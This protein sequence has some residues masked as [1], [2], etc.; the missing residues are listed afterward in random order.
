MKILIDGQTLST[1]DIHRG[2]GVVFS[3]ILVNLL[4]LGPYHEFFLAVYDDYAKDQI[5]NIQDTIEILRLGKKLDASSDG[6]ISYADAI[7][8]IVSEK[9]IDCLWIPNPVMPNVNFIKKPLECKV[10]ITFYDL[11]PFIFEEYYLN[12]WPANLKE[13]YLGRLMSLNEIGDCILP[14]SNCTK[15]DLINLLNIDPSKIQTVYLGIERGNYSRENK[16][17]D[18][19]REKY[20]LYVGGFDPRK[21]MMNSILAF[22]R[23]TEKYPYP[24]LKYYIVCDCDQITRDNFSAYIKDQSLLEKVVLTGY[25]SDRELSMLYKN[26][27]LLFFPSLYEGF[28]LPIIEA[29]AAGTPVAASNR[30]SIPEL[31]GDAGLL[32]DPENIDDMALK[33]HQI[34]SD[35]E[36]RERLISNGLQISKKFSWEKTAKQYLDIIEGLPSAGIS[37]RSHKIATVKESKLKIAYFSPIHPQISGISQYSKE[38]LLE[39]KKYADIDLFLDKNVIPLEPEII[40]NFRY[41]CY[42]DF[43]NMVKTENYDAILYHI[44]NNPLHEYIYWTSL[45][46]PGI[47]VLHDYVLHPFIKHITLDKSK[48]IHYLIEILHAYPNKIGN[49]IKKYIIDGPNSINV[50]EYPLNERI[51]RTSKKVIVHSKYVKSLLKRYSNVY[52][53][54][55]GRNPVYYSE[56]DIVNNKISLQ[57]NND[58]ILVSIFGFMN[59]NKRIDVVIRVFNRLQSE[60]SNIRLLLVGLI[61]SDVIEKVKDKSGNIDVIGYVTEDVYYRYLTVSDIII[62]LRYPTMGETSGTLLDAMAF[63]KPVIVSN[64]GSYKETPDNCCWKVDL[65]ENE[66]ELLYQFLKELI[67]NRKL[68]EVMGKN[69]REFIARNHKWEKIALQY[70]QTIE[71]AKNQ[72]P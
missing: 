51:P 33:L 35:P 46:Y 70:I 56:N 65:D 50:L 9:K 36:L 38:L 69:G 59:P 64:V 2:I 47:T 41:F 52:I 60:F 58:D 66:E 67:R 61:N 16:F 48:K 25:M 22:K 71:E 30:S 7:I 63:G 32:F 14:I 42:D 34:L 23:L 62:N 13:D 37:E 68:R 55:H 8:R 6:R 72:T 15:N 20:I 4:R 49:I 24:N 1:P 21:N 3:E 39:L 29:M 10:L 26:A 19:T 57:L 27:E 18:P 11:I 5:E 43:K 12:N 31:V 44:G 54:P 17:S 28:G 45:R 40:K 53:I